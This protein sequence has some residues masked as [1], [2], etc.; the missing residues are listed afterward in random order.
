MAVKQI[1]QT[2]V[3]FTDH[4][5]HLHRLGTVIETRL[6]VELR[7]YCIKALFQGFNISIPFIEAKDNS[8]KKLTCDFIIIL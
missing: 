3:E 4:D 2:V 8:G 1:Q 6:H 7:F 5:E